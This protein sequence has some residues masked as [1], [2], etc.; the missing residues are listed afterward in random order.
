MSQRPLIPGAGGI[1]LLAL[2]I[3]SLCAAGCNRGSNAAQMP[4]PPPPH[5]TATEGV[6]RDV[7]FY[8]YEIGRCAGNKTVTVMPQ[9]AG[10]VDGAH[11]VEGADVKK[12]DL[13]FTIDPRPFKA[14]VAQAEATLAQSRENLKLAESDYARV[15][16]LK[17]TSAV[18]QTEYDQKKSAAAVA[19]A[20]VEAAQAALDTANLNLEYCTIKSPITGRTGMRM[21]DPGNI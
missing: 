12:D 7:P 20:Q 11:F 15:E 21:V 18:S 2:L 6:V 4:A 13:L 1:L 19:A 10:R 3:V 17:G 8:I 9:I 14:V 16:A 5:V